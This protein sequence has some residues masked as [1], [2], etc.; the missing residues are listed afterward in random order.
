MRNKVVKSKVI[1]IIIEGHLRIEAPLPSLRRRRGYQV[2]ISL[3]WVG[4]RRLEKGVWR[5]DVLP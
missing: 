4:E 1:Y 2:H 5:N 3:V